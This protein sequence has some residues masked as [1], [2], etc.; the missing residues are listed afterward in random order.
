MRGS[1]SPARDQSPIV[2][3]SETDICFQVDPVTPCQERLP[4]TNARTRFEGMVGR[5][6]QVFTCADSS[7]V[8]LTRGGA[9][10]SLVSAVYLAFSDHRPLVLTPDAVWITLAQGFAQH[11]NH[12]ANALRSRVVTHKGTVTLYATTWELANNEDWA[13]VIQQ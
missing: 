5:S 13:S 3:R 1:A 11:I 2:H 10:H 7:D 12:H 9:D 4:L 6:V 8:V